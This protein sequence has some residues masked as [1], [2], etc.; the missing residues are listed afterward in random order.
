M[1]DITQLLAML[2]NNKISQVEY[3]E[4]LGVSRQNVQSWKATPNGIPKKYIDKT[5]QFIKER[6][7]KK[8]KILTLSSY[9]QL[10]N[11]KTQTNNTSTKA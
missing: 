10:Q 5:A 3:A 9:L 6:I 8:A 7:D 4:Y 11:T 1:K 2:E